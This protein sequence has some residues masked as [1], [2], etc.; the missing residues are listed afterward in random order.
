MSMRHIFYTGNGTAPAGVGLLHVGRFFVIDQDGA[1]RYFRYEGSGEQDPT[2]TNGFVEN[3]PGNVIGNGFHT[4][5]HLFVS[6]REGQTMATTI[7]AV[8]EN[9]DL[10][11]FRYSGHGEQDPTGVKGFEGPNQGNQIGNGF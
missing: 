1:L 3:N 7:F 5:R 2:G 9:G 8:A 10:S 6:P 4:F 11:F